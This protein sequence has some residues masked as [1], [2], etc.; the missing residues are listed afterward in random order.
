MKQ[1]N[2]H[3]LIFL[4]LL[5]LSTSIYAQEIPLP[6]HPRPDF[7]REQWQNLNGTWAFTFDDLDKGIQEG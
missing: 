3:N 1:Q 6:E 5:L 2:L 4:L 7:Q